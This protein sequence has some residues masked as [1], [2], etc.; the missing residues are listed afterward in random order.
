MEKD[1]RPEARAAQLREVIEEH[2][3]RY[4]EE[5]APTI[6]DQE[7]DALMR[8]LVEIEQA[9][10]EL[11]T[12]DSPTR[13][14]GG[15]AL[16]EFAHVTHRTPMLS[17]DN[18]YSEEEVGEWF[19]RLEKHLPGEE[20]VVRDEAEIGGGKRAEAELAAGGVEQRPLGL[21]TAAFD[22]E[23]QRG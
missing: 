18:T 14:V 3:R 23:D 11:A 17:L 7:Y 12:E 16:E 1:A 6:S 21:R 19:K 2:N 22:A 5:A 13:R 9:H 15:K 10:P 8:E 4:Y 20:I